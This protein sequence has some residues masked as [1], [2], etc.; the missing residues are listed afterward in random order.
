[1]RELTGKIRDFITAE[2]ERRH[3][4]IW[5]K[6]PDEILARID[7]QRIKTTPPSDYLD[8]GTAM[9]VVPAILLP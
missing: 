4:F 8:I 7:R 2:T 1:M 5:T 3:P 9:S 6:T